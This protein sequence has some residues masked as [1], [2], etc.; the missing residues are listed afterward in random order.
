MTMRDLILLANGLTQ[1]A[2]LEAEIA[3]LPES[4]PAGALAETVRVPLDSSYV[5][6]PGSS[7][8]ATPGPGSQGDTPLQPY[9][10]VLVLRQGE[11]SLQRT[12]V[13]SGQV[14]SPGRYSL[15]SKTERLADLIERAGGLTKEA[16][17]G[18]IQFYRSYLGNT[19]AGTDRL[20][21]LAPADVASRDTTRRGLPERVGI[22]LPRVLENPKF[23]DNII[24]ASGDS[25][26]IPEYNPIVLVQG[27]VNSPGAVAYTPGKNLDWYVD[28]AGGY[29]QTG[30]ARHP[31]VTQ[32][33]GSREGVKRKQVFADRV[34]HPKAGAVVFVPT[35]T[36]TEPSNNLT[37]ILGTAAQLLGA[38][39][40][41]IVV[42]RR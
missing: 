13:L 26:H 42:A 1:D 14:K 39:V 28:Q 30:D 12:V 21:S 11:W 33:G 17:P 2:Q 15:R 24:L 25:I 37:A 32:P 40:T 35:L 5:F 20:R 29:T 8:A 34:P 31:Y 22:D 19:P 9:D 3:R 16:Y 6:G 18:G 27:A 36:T 41:I 7:A 4:R 10:N 38:L 23:R